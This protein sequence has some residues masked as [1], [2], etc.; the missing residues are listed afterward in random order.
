MASQQQNEWVQRI[1]GVAMTQAGGDDDEDVDLSPTALGLDASDLWKAATQ[2]FR[3]ATETVDGQIGALQA[4][5]RQEMDPELD[6]ISEFG[7]NALTR[8]TRVPLMA[9]LTEAGDGSGERLKSAAPKLEKAI[10]AFRSVI[11]TDPKI[12]AADNNPFDVEVTIR[13]TFAGV[14]EQLERVVKLAA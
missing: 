4:A 5:L 7:L 3:T 10:A 11:A 6:K 13:S 14:L 8:N 2:A 1:L 12:A 9:A